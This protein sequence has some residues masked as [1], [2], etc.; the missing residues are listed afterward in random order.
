MRPTTQAPGLEGHTSTNK[1]MAWLLRRLRELGI[2]V[3]KTKG[4]H[5]KVYAPGGLYFMSSTP[6][7]H[8]AFKNNLSYLR[9]LGVDV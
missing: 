7:D 3:E 1:E 6:S 9:K 5:F 8:R 2:R 4:N